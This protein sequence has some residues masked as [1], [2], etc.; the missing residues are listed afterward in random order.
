MVT[1]PSSA[2]VR[3]TIASTAAESVAAGVCDLALGVAVFPCAHNKK[4]CTPHAFQ[5]GRG[6]YAILE[7]ELFS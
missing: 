7:Q 3:A 6:D 5:R 2:A 1:G 4:P